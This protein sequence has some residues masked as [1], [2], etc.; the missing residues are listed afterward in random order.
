MISEYKTFDVKPFERTSESYQ[1]S[2]AMHD[3]VKK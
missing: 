3:L 2:V 1:I